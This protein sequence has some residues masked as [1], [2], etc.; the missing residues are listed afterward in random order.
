M[1]KLILTD[2]DGTLLND[3]NEI[4][5]G[6][7]PV[8]D[9]LLDKNIIFGAASGRQYFNLLKRFDKVKNNML[10]VAENGTFVMYKGKEIMVNSLDREIAMKLIEIG[11]KID[12]SYLILCGKNGAYI[13]NTDSRL[14]KETEKYYERYEI[15]EDITKVDDEI[16]KV[17]ICDFSG[18]EK[19]SFNY[20]K[21]Y[22][23]DVKV[24]ISGEIW[25]D[26]TDKRANKGFAIKK[27]QEI[28]NIEYE[29]T[30]VFGDYLNDVEMLRNAYYSFAME[31]A[32][33]DLKKE[34]RFIAKS[35]NDN[36]VVDAIRNVALNNDAL[37]LAK[38]YLTPYQ[39]IGNK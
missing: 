17:T 25:L 19:N 13:E 32:H 5:E 6:F 12:N 36:G 28:L 33:K 2:M 37:K 26:I 24:T 14:I 15:V 34:A 3:N 31:N 1:I 11:R 38:E 39:V 4:N 16:L 10:F 29:E 23:D 30:M 27:I 18:S 35:N 7:Y 22:M 9:K 8:F 20:Y 21:D